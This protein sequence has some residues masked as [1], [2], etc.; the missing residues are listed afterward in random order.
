MSSSHSRSVAV[1]EDRL[2]AK[3]QAGQRL[4]SELASSGPVATSES[5]T[6][7]GL[8]ITETFADGSIRTTQ[9]L[10]GPG[11]AASARLYVAH[12][13]FEC[14][15]VHCTLIYSKADTKQVATSPYATAGA[16]ISAAC[17]PAWAC[18]IATGIFVD[19]AHSAYN[20][21]MCMALQKVIAVGPPYA[22]IVSCRH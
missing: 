8:V 15:V 13:T 21:G 11:D 10:A 19:T 6:D 22:V 14:N 5:K 2:I 17:G 16:I 4:D 18:G 3:L 1:V 12:P 7:E 20:S 9:D